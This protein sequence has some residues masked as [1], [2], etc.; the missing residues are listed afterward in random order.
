MVQ[1]MIMCRSEQHCAALSQADDIS[2]KGACNNDVM[3]LVQVRAS[4]V[5][6]INAHFM[7]ALA[8]R[9]P[10]ADFIHAGYHH[11]GLLCHINIQR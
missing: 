8:A 11:P 10:V 7:S 4:A 3:S 9:S 2:V 5:L 6:G 1:L